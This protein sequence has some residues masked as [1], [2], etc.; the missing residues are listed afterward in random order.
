V[1]PPVAA[2]GPTPTP[3]TTTTLTPP[4]READAA[5]TK[6]MVRAK[7]GAAAPSTPASDDLPVISVPE[8]SPLRESGIPNMDDVCGSLGYG[9]DAW[10]PGQ[11]KPNNLTGR[12]LYGGNIVNQWTCGKNGQRLT[13]GLLT[14]GC[15]I[16]NPG[17][18]AKT[19][20]PNYAYSAI[21]S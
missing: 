18:V 17:S 8:G 11:T 15:Q 16:W 19:W 9:R 1:D 21:C 12:V 5:P 2:N 14:E 20:N 6:P 10:L 13:A 7:S 4:T 3:S